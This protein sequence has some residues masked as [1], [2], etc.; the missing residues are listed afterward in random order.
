MVLALITSVWVSLSS[1]VASLRQWLGSL[2]RSTMKLLWVG[3]FHLSM[4]K[5]MMNL[6]WS[7]M[8]SGPLVILDWNR[9]QQACNLQKTLKFLMLWLHQFFL[10]NILPRQRQLMQIYLSLFILSISAR[11][12]LFC[13]FWREMFWIG[14]WRDFYKVGG[15]LELRR[16]YERQEKFSAQL[17]Q[18]GNH[19]RI[20]KS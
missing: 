20:R 15:D 18:W 10:S 1:L 14:F 5:Q 16:K 4:F 11:N 9:W 8:K 12:V 7:D 2:L 3:Y 6:E 19:C 13:Q 17:R